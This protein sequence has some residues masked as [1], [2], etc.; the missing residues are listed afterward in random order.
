MGNL[1]KEK[2]SNQ[3]HSDELSDLKEQLKKN[4]LDNESLKKKNSDLVKKLEK[5]EEELQ[6]ICKEYKVLLNKE[7]LHSLGAHVPSK[8]YLS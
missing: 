4:E 8:E 7:K 5:V 2:E 3:E 6:L 1:S